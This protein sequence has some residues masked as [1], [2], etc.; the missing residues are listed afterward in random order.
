MV[1]D[2]LV[3]VIIV[4]DGVVV[5][6]EQF[7]HPNV[8]HYDAKHAVE[9]FSNWNVDEIVLLNISHK[10]ESHEKFLEL[11]KSVAS[12]CMVPLSVGGNIKTFENGLDLIRNGADK[13]VINTL[14]NTQPEIISKLSAHFGK[15][16]IVASIDVKSTGELRPQVFVDKGR[17]N[18]GFELSYW[19]KYCEQYGAGEI[20]LN[21]IDH[22]GMRHGYDLAS[23]KECV[24]CTNLPIIIF[25]GASQNK[26][27]ED[28]LDAGASAVAAAN[29]WHYT[30]MATKRVKKYLIQNGYNFRR[31]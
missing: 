3:A 4:K 20:F 10:S 28:G 19:I 29:M 6:S 23:L 14:F 2:R 30:E 21:N 13:L 31:N 26:H 18:T 24:K 16:C 27:F 7:R 12:V 9:A 22:D 5:Q 15:Q 25:G 11:L 8:I 1:R 17:V